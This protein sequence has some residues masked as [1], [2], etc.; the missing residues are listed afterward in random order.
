MAIEGLMAAKSRVEVDA[1][2]DCY[3]ASHA[4]A[5]EWFDGGLLAVFSR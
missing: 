1:E 2:A 4:K 3:I 5:D